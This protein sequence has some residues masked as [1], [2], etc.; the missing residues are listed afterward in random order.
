MPA[1]DVTLTAQWT[2]INVEYT[3]TFDSNGGSVVG[4][5]DVAGGSKL[6]KPTD[7]TRSGYK[8]VGWFKDTALTEP[9][10]FTKDVVTE[11]ITLYAK[12]EPTDKP[13]PTIYKV[14]YS[15]NGGEG[16]VPKSELHYAGEF[17]TVKSADLKR[18]GYTFKG[19]CDSYTQISYKADEEF[20][21]PFRDVCLTAIW[22]ENKPPIQG[23]EVSVTFVVDN[24]IYGISTTHINTALEE[25][26]QPDPVKEG[27]DF[28]GWYTKD[29]QIF[30][31]ETI[32]KDDMTV[33][34]EWQLNE[35]YVIVTFVIDNE[36][37]LTKV[38]R[39]DSIQEP[40]V[41]VKL[42]K[43]LNGWYS[44]KELQN[45]F[46]FNTVITEDHLTLY[47][48]WKDSSNFMIWF[49]FGLFAFFIAAVIASTKKVSF[50]ESEDDEEKYASV[51][52]IGKGTLGDKFPQS[53]NN[54]N[55]LGW[56]SEEGELITEETE[57]KQ[58]MKLYARWKD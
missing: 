23:K 34:A 30:T 40:Y 35:D 14:E 39:K 45:K 57:I 5:V 22:E 27:F 51:I 49:V 47:A 52:I 36:V 11:D 10:N 3:V 44:D 55:F 32:V 9:W 6:S 19:W 20:R 50:Y 29:G 15:A 48:E 43:E 56:Y 7:P 13:T 37:Y 21:M 17:V 33:Y 26:M 2:L 31:S 46:D 1:S 24:E 38:C 53:P 18:E 41:P 54:Q 58:S 25:A 16:E 28:L 4:S 42:G 12:W 8:F